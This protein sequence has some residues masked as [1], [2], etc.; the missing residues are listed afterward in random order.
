MYELQ[1]DTRQAGTEAGETGQGQ[2]PGAVAWLQDNTQ[3]SQEVMP[4][5]ADSEFQV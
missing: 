2:V 4:G 3:E 1:R 5:I